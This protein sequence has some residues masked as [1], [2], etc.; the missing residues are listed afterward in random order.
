MEPNEVDV[1]EVLE[2]QETAEETVETPV[3]EEKEQ[4]RKEKEELEKKNKQLFARLKKE[5]QEDVSL[6][7]KDQLALSQAGVSPE[8][9]DELIEFAKFKRISLTEALKTPTMRTILAEKA[10]ER[11][12]ASAT[13]TKGARGV[14]K[15]T[16]EEILQ[17]AER[18]GE[19]PD[20]DE[21]MKELFLARIHRK[22]RK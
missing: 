16:G 20:T 9:V 10:E 4:L 11:R 8:D 17:H 2:T 6:P 12:T 22:V 1:P 3:D 5:G 21:G 7:L 15:P 18:T 13:Q 14:Q 19:V